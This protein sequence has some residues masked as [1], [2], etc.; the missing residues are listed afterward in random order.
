[1][2]VKMYINTFRCA[3]LTAKSKTYLKITFNE[4]V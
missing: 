4:V 3:D 1:M 2:Y